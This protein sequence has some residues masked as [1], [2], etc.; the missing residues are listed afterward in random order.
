MSSSIQILGLLPA[1]NEF[2]WVL[3][4]GSAEEEFTVLSH[5]KVVVPDFGNR[6]QELSW[7]FTNVVEAVGKMAV[8]SICVVQGALN[9]SGNTDAVLHR[10]QVEGVLLAALGTIKKDVTLIKRA[11]IVSKLG[12]KRGSKVADI[13]QLQAV[14][15][16]I[17]LPKHFDEALA[18]AILAS[19]QEPR[20]SAP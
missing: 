20:V 15:T 5:K 8:S 6:E 16:A 17:G 10:A 18:A 7:V 12:M 19:R 1:K 2:R 11:A 13:P 14:R 3:A 9:S 4:E